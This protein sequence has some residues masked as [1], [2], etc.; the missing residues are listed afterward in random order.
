MR[1]GVGNWASMGMLEDAIRIPRG[2]PA[3]GN[4]PGKQF[5]AI[6][7]CLFVCVCLCVCVKAVCVCVCVCVCVVVC[8]LWWCWWVCVCVCGCVC[9]CVG[10]C[11]C[12]FVCVLEVRLAVRLLSGTLL[13]NA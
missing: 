1:P 5:K 7:G 4:D 9:V 6:H 13:T 2:G 11:E 8:V 12:L 10:G 3:A